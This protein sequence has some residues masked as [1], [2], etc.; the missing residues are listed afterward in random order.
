MPSPKA[1]PST[2]SSGITTSSPITRIAMAIS[3]QRSQAGSRRASRATGACRAIALRSAMAT[4][5]A[6]VRE[7]EWNRVDREQADERCRQQQ[8]GDGNRA[9]VV[10]F[11]QPDRDQQR[12]DLGLVR[13]VA[14]DEDHRAVFAQA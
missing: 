12:R 6:L 14:G 9:V 13:Q 7:Q 10:V 4:P 2:I 1:A 8:G 5:I 3:D 11:L